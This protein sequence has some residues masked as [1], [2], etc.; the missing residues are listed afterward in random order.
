MVFSFCLLPSILTPL[1]EERMCRE[2]GRQNN[3]KIYFLV[4]ILTQPSL[5]SELFLSKDEINLSKPSMTMLLLLLLL[6]FDLLFTLIQVSFLQDSITSI[7]S[8]GDIK[9]LLQF[10]FAFSILTLFFSRCSRFLPVCFSLSRSFPLFFFSKS[11]R[12]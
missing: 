8:L 2:G 1:K 6:H 5:P 3:S 7:S 10:Y 12:T 4:G 11:S 9:I